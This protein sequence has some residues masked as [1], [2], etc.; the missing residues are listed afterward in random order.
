MSS[1][2][3][4]ENHWPQSFLPSALCR[5]YQDFK[6]NLLS[7]E[8]SQQCLLGG[9]HAWRFPKAATCP[10]AL[11]DSKVPQKVTASPP[12]P[13]QILGAVLSAHCKW[14]RWTP[15][16]A[17]SPDTQNLWSAAAFWLFPNTHTN[18]ST[19]EKKPKKPEKRRWNPAQIAKAWAQS[20]PS[21]RLPQLSQLQVQVPEE[22]FEHSHNTRQ[23]ERREAVT[24]SCYCPEGFFRANIRAALFIKPQTFQFSLVYMYIYIHRYTR[25]ESEYIFLF[26]FQDM[27]LFRLFGS[28][29]QLWTTAG[30]IKNSR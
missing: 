23:G 8:L 19:K 30:M 27:N 17:P 10:A 26:V 12:K 3:L 16:S 6:T 29:E 15:I 5:Q 14:S 7:K 21:L 18:I 1:V 28:P 9:W 25:V 24:R 22:N 13:L 2:D 11:L 20:I 4:E